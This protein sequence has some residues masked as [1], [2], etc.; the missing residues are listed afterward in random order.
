MK[1]GRRLGPRLDHVGTAHGPRRNY[2]GTTQGWEMEDRDQAR[3]MG[4]ATQWSGTEDAMQIGMT[5][6]SK[7]RLF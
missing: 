7:W 5:S 2:V 4:Q 3:A 1:D 6:Q